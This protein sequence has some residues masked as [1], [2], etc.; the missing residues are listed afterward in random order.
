MFLKIPFKGK[1][2]AVSFGALLLA[3]SSLASRGLGVLRDSVFA[4]VFGI[5]STGGTFALDAYFVAF[6]IP[7]FLYTLLI[8][9]AMSTAFIPMYM[10]LRQKESEEKAS[11]FASRVIVLLFAFLPVLSVVAFFAAPYL[12]P[13]LAPGFTPELQD[14]SVSLTRIML[15]SPFFMGLSGLFQGIENAHK[16]FLGLALAPIFYNLAIIASAWFFGAVYGVYAL[17]VG[18]CV[19]ALLHFLVQVPGTLVTSFHFKIKRPLWD[20]DIKEFFILLIPRLAGNIIFQAT[21]FVDTILATTLALGSLSIYSYAL[22]LESLPYGVVAV[23][24]ST[25]VFSTLTEHADHHEN[26]FATL[27]QTFSR[28]LFWV[29]PATI[30]LYLLREPVVRVILGGG[31]FNEEAVRM[32]T[33]MLGFFVWAA[34][35]QS[36]IP[37][38]SRAFYSRKETWLPVKLGMIGMFSC[39]ILGVFFIKGLGLPIYG[40]AFSN[41][42]ATL[43]YALLMALF[44][45]KQIKRSPFELIDWHFFASIGAALVMM[46]STLL[47][48]IHYLADRPL[49]LLLVGVS[50]GG[51]VYLG[52]YGGVK[53]LLSAPSDNSKC[54]NE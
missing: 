14:I 43:I 52:V 28:V 1:M 49:W 42:I 6:K 27:K 25:A 11:L 41:V 51:A 54:K 19:G 16:R 30:G 5:G 46:I 48:T 38:F 22:N 8:L 35:P 10:G 47:L 39:I 24:F 29:I 18:V 34:I 17:A 20:K 45:L 3:V 21:I 53:K 50:G 40:L 31:Q 32:T 13:L 44:L 9:G 7:D 2:S 4:H 37:L 26:F 23:S 12:M 15:I 33:L 36:M